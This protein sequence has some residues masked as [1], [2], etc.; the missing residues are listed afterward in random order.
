MDK[1]PRSCT[2]RLLLSFLVLFGLCL[3]L[4]MI[5]LLS[6]RNLPIEESSEQLSDVDKARLLESLH[7][8]RTLG[9]QVWQ[10]WGSADNP[11][12]VWNRSYEF[13]VNYN[14][15]VPTSWSRVS[16]DDLNGQE[17]FRRTAEDP[18]NFAIRVGDTWAASMATKNTT[19]VFLIN[20]F[21]ENLPAPIKQVFPYRFL[22]Q[23][24][25]TQI[26][27]LLHETFHVFQYQNA[28]NRINAAESIHGL[29]DEYEA[30]AES[31]RSEWRKEAELLAEA[32][33]A[34]PR[35]EKAE[36]VLQFLAARDGRRKDHQLGN[37]F[38]D[39]ERWLEWEEGTAKY[40]EVAILKQANETSDYRALPAMENDPDFGQYQTIDQRWSQEI[41]QLRYQTSPGESRFYATG[42]AQAFLLDDLM[43]DWKEQYWMEDVF[44]EDLLRSAMIGS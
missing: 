30:A 19:D 5:S 8:K 13:L 2:Y 10:G 32:L 37:N 12:I 40:I 9:D 35:D 44:L 34:K 22:L 14:G 7:L 23:P 33:E 36:L 18:Q 20:A 27:G 21:R 43:P 26:G 24:S 25:E 6:N 17:Y 38:I 15:D 42:M 1:K 28:P 16:V 31:F 29:G 41:F 4:S 11:I 3:L 39:Y